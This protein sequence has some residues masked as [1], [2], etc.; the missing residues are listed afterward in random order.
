MAIPLLLMAADLP[1][2]RNAVALAPQTQRAVCRCD[3]AKTIDCLNGIM[4][5]VP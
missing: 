2:S 3:S 1:A 4:W 5:Q